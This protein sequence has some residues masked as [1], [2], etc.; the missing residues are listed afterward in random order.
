MQISCPYGTSNR[1]ID[2]VLTERSEWIRGALV[3]VANMD[4]MIRTGSDG[5]SAILFGKKY[6]VRFES[7]GRNTVFFDDD[8]IVYK[9]LRYDRVEADKLFYERSGETLWKLIDCYRKQWDEKICDA[10]GFDRPLIK[11]KDMKSR[12]GSCTPAKSRISMSVR[13]VHYPVECTQYVLLHEYVHFLV[14][15][16]GKEF[17]DLVE[18]Y[19]PQYNEYRK[20][21]K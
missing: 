21:M 5:S 17:Y 8:E 1:Q 19:M 20:I 11:I 16:H 10:N 9:M 18:R 2:Q 13:L 7:F 12:W 3:K 14:Q 4:D 15:N 6:P